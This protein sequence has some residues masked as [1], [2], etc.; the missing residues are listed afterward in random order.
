MYKKCFGPQ[1]IVE[2]S[3][4]QSYVNDYIA[5][6]NK[7]DALDIIANNWD[8]I[9]KRILD[10]N[11]NREYEALAAQ[12]RTNKFYRNLVKHVH[13]SGNTCIMYWR[14]GSQTKARWNAAEDFDPEKA[15]LVCMAR[16]LFAD[17]NIYNE[18]LQKY[19]DD[20]WDH[21]EK[22]FWKDEDEYNDEEF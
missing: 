16:K 10:V 5:Q 1:T 9:Q 18:V 6:S 15:M 19:A 7:K 14:D 13:W 12:Q 3:F 8:E 22:T 4:L 2:D 21:F 20:G 11:A 17:T